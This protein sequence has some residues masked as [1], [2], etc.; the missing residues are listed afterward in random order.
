MSSDSSSPI[1]YEE[2]FQQ[3]LEYVI[4]PLYVLV[5]C[6]VCLNSFIIAVLGR[7]IRIRPSL[8]IYIN[9]LVVD[10]V[11]VCAGISLSYHFK[12]QNDFSLQYFD[13]SIWISYYFGL[14]LFFGLA[15]MRII[16]MKCPNPVNGVMMANILI[17]VSCLVT[18]AI[19]A[20]HSTMKFPD[21]KKYPIPSSIQSTLIIFLGFSTL[22]MN[23]YIL[24][25]VFKHQDAVRA[26]HH[27]SAN[28][29][30]VLLFADC[31]ICSIFALGVNTYFFY[32][33]MTGRSCPAHP[34][35]WRDF[36]L[37]TKAGRHNTELVCLLIQSVGNNVILLLQKE[38]VAVMRGIKEIV[39]MR[40][41]ER[42]PGYSPY[43]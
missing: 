27:T 2:K 8:R 25:T 5:F 29:T 3:I 37:C 39:M 7:D 24:L 1:S 14:F 42:I 20:A 23:L 18:L 4:P 16:V 41:E 15:L 26:N 19:F 38:S 22:F 34:D 30:A 43:L 32:L 28:L 31:F 9:L 35:S 12:Y 10:I 40:R 13:H 21:Y 17:S 6:L 36:F 33:F 11:V